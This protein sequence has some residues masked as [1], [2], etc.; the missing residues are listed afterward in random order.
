MLSSSCRHAWRAA[1]SLAAAVSM[2]APAAA[3]AANVT[4]C[5]G[6]AVCYCINGDFKDAIAEKVDYYRKAI[7]AERAKGKA[8]GYMSVPLSST[9]GGYFNVNRE[10]AEKIKERVE[11]RLGPNSAWLLNPTAREADLPTLNNVRAGQGDY[12]LMWTLILEGPKALGED[13]DFIYFVGPTDF[14]GFFGL[15]GKDDM[16]RIAAYFDDRLAKDADLK[17]AVERGSVSK[18]A[19]RNYY[20]LRAS[21]AFSLGAHDEWNVIRAVNQRRRDDKALGV[22]NQLPV[23]FDGRAVSSG[24]YEQQVAGGNVG[25][26]KAD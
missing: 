7:A 19:F 2:F 8:I 6:V 16:D 11:T 17:R 10:V 9:G 24:E 12:L 22:A 21:A 5:T 15:T 25:A 18:A 23:L 4:E 14:A 1:L 3:I 20:A 26:C 13:F